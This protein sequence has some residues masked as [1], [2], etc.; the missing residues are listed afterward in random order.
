[1]AGGMSERGTC[2]SDMKGRFRQCVCLLAV[3]SVL[4]SISACDE[5]TPTSVD[6]DQS[7]M[8]GSREDGPLVPYP[9]TIKMTRAEYASPITTYIDGEDAAD[10][11][12]T[13]F[14]R[15]KLNIVW[16]NAW[17][18]AEDG[19]FSRLNLA[20]ASGDLPDVFMVN[21]SQLKHLINAD[22]I[23]DLTDVY[24]TY[25]CDN[26][27]T[28]IEYDDRLALSIPTVNGRLYAVPLTRVYE[29]S[30]GFL[31]LRTDW[32][33]KLGLQAP[34]TLEEFKDYVATVKESGIAGRGTSGFCF[35][36]P[37]SAAFEGLAHASGAYYDCW[38]RDDDGQSLVYSTFRPE[39]RNALLNMQQMYRDGLI[40]R[41]FAV[42]GPLLFERM[43]AGQYG[44]LLGEFS[45]PA[46][47]KYSVM[48]N[49]EA[50]WDAFPV[51]L[52]P[53]AE[54]RPQSDVF[55]S[56][57]VVVRKD[58][59]HPEALLKS[60]NLWA[61]VWLADGIYR[62]WYT[63][64]MVTTYNEV[65]NCGKY[66][67]PYFFEGVDSGIEI[68]RYIRSA[69]ASGNPTE[70]I[71]KYPYARMTYS[72][73]ADE[74]APNFISGE[75]WSLKT[76]YMT[77]ER[78]F[79]EKYHTLQFNQFQGLLSNEATYYQNALNQDIMETFIDIIMGEDIDAFDRLAEDWE[80]GGG[81]KI[82]K[83]VNNWYHGQSRG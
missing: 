57:Y 28:N 82:K 62:E 15:N 55:V 43:M 2:M 56:G 70:E 66:A 76:V 49:P 68:G 30:V 11:F 26:L 6:T 41:D 73:M 21:A 10:N 16:D 54:L 25:I 8:S 13:D 63:D 83:E 36:G 39:M 50:T 61:Q 81:D 18:C 3:M 80:A 72:Y 34:T 79:D 1:M 9:E 69:Y 5:K 35:L 59:A 7:S 42:A 31:W 71:K 58:C 64:Q 53:Q 47:L 4:F 51:P 29:G 74:T 65:V 20:I 75:G 33:Q 78:I 67:L 46:M 44:I 22:V 38:V 32:M 23:M 37:G 77:S 12:I 24:E 52:N 45:Y 14:Y 48:S 17:S 60:M 19:Y 27:R 40:D